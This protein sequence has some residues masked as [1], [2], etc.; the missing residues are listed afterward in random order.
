MKSSPNSSSFLPPRLI[1][2]GPPNGSQHARL[3]IVK[4]DFYEI[5]H[6]LRYIALSYCWGNH[7]S[8]RT[9]T[10][11]ISEMRKEIPLTSL[12]GTIRD[13]I[14]ITRKLCIQY[15]WVD[16]LCILQGRGNQV[17]QQ[18]L[19]DWQ[20]HSAIMGDIY[21][22]AFVTLGAA[23]GIHADSGIFHE[24]KLP[25]YCRIPL[26]IQNKTEFID[27]CSAENREKAKVHLSDKIQP[28]YSRSWAL[29]ERA[30]SRRFVA[31]QTGQIYWSC[32][33]E[34]VLEDGTAVHRHPEVLNGYSTESWSSSTWQYFVEKYS[35]TK[36]TFETDKLPALSG[37][38][39]TIQQMSK[40]EYLA[41]LWKG[42]ILDGLIWM[43]RS[44]SLVRRP[45]QYRAP[46]W[47]WAALNGEVK[48]LEP[49][50]ADPDDDSGRYELQYLSYFVDY[51]ITPSGK[52]PFGEV[53]CGYISMRGTIKSLDGIELQGFELVDSGTNRILILRKEPIG[54]N[55]KS[56]GIIFPD[57]TDLLIEPHT[58]NTSLQ[59]TGR[60]LFMLPIREDFLGCMGL[61]LHYSHT[62]TLSYRR[63]GLFLISSWRR[64][65]SSWWFDGCA[66]QT[67]NIE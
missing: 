17:D 24:R 42:T 66:E 23:A 14:F 2:V 64:D 47:S 32:S 20:E 45:S 7:C 16:A 58:R 61:V 62:N 38:A 54:K 21:G 29:Q 11:N 52:N 35:T 26:T 59:A 49:W 4:D 43:T 65:G 34:V 1:D 40:D 53:L 31:Y 9:T 57:T 63:V 22:N 48:W 15:L 30:L 60:S 46:S 12:P 55:K 10:S 39:K 19:D 8:F 13:A 33:E 44:P 37:L 18:A 28:L 41:G 56:F 6:D 27:L 25:R 5:Q 36:A 3:C 67:I 51:K 50:I